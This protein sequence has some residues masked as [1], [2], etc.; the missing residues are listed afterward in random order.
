MT[1]CDFPL[2][3]TLAPTA[4]PRTATSI[5]T[6]TSLSHPLRIDELG[7]G[8]AGRIGLCICPGKRGDSLKG[9][10]WQRDLALD[11]AVVQR[12]RPDAVL[13]LIE[14]HEF[15]LLG[16]ALL[17]PQLL[18]M[19]ISWHHL[20]IVDMQ[21]P[22]ARFEAAWRQLGPVLR[23]CLG[24]GGRLLVHCRGGLGRAGT[25]AARLLVE[26]GL[27][28]AEAIARVRLA[29][30]GAIETGAQVGHLLGLP[31]ICMS[32]AP[33]PTF[34]PFPENP[35][36]MKSLALLDADPDGAA[37]DPAGSALLSGGLDNVPLDEI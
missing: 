5:P 26:Q 22:D 21:P 31:P 15:A 29:R 18:A 36:G 23:S 19:G 11:L 20:P 30:P 37:L 34:D 2:M 25:V 28:A 13:T 4:A 35:V 3:S 10:R 33:A 17:G 27:P 9:A 7:A 16:V 32:A 24:A 1:S 12:W 8:A 6:R 14:D